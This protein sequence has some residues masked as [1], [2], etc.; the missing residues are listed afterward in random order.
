MKLILISI[1]SFFAVSSS[2]GQQLY[3][4]ADLSYVNEVEDCGA[5]FRNNGKV[6]DPY[7]LFAENGAN[8]VRVRLWHNPDWTQYSDFE[9]VVKTIKRAKENNMEV[10]LDFH[11]SDT[12]AD[13]HKQFIPA[14][15]ASVKNGEILGDSLYQYTYNTLK[16]L[17]AIDL[18]PKMVQVGNETNSEILQLKDT[19]NIETINWERNIKLLNR[20]IEAVNKVA[21]ETGKEIQTM[22]HIAQPE[23]AFPWFDEAF[24]NGIHDF[25]WIGLSYYPTWSTY[26][27]SELGNAVDSLKSA[28]KK[29][30]MIVETA[31]PYMLGG[32][33]DANDILTEGALIPGY[34]ATPKGQLDYLLE[35]TRQTIKGGG[36]G[37]IYW[38]PAWVSSSC[39]T[40]WGQ[41]SHWENATFFD[42]KNKNEAL[43]AFKFYDQKNYK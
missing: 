23:N 33:D 34:P 25:E 7:A 6:V 29:R 42:A 30:I 18:L 17:A 4:G 8:L 10:L 21:E 2:Y 22:I 24:K 9:D 5:E 19:M 37:V 20:G 38:E 11:Y 32:I 14:A 28:Y 13:P 40:L 27:M 35:L 16:K 36:E 43:P 39:S 1:L 31:Y 3:L 41:G 15:W 26:G 12:W